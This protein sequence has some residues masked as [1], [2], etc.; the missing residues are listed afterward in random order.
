MF[1]FIQ[2]TF[3]LIFS[4]FDDA[5]KRLFWGYLLSAV[6]IALTFQVFVQKASLKESIK[7]L[8]NKDIWWS[9]SSRADYK[10][11][12]ANRLLF[13]G[14][15]PAIISQL[16]IATLIFSWLHQFASPDLGANWPV[17]VIIC[18]FT[19]TVFLIDDLSK[20]WLHRI[21]HSNE[22]LWS[23]HSVHHS[24]T[25]LTP[26][27]VLRIHPIESVF[28]V[29]R[30]ALVQGICIGF[31]VFIFGSRVD[32]F[33]IL[34]VNIFI[35]MFNAFGSNLRH[36]PVPISYP[37]CVEGWLMSPAQHQIHHSID[38]EHYDTNF[39]VALSIWDRLGGT[40]KYGSCNQK[41]SYGVK[42]NN[43][44]DVNSLWGLYVQPV[45]RAISCLR[46]WRK[47]SYWKLQKTTD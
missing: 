14:V 28:F 4:S 31:F 38:Q 10:M 42:D 18:L 19:L 20:Y 11:L 2:Y 1:D 22:F 36:S 47:F 12:I 24:A 5:N 32:L 3:D 8:T 45:L 41:I 46:L 40:L 33:S 6:I 25:D 39:G 29:L 7:D 27:T 13:L 17:P 15:S 23:F 9:K 21:M 35:F 16:T 30:S 34:G 26:F 43:I 37:D 44:K